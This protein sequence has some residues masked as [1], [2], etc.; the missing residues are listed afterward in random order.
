MAYQTLVNK[1]CILWSVRARSFDVPLDN[2][3]FGI[4]LVKDSWMLTAVKTNSFW[5]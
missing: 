2:T 5:H 3:V 1:Q 4:T